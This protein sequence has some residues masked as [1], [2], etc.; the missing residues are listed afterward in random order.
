MLSLRIR[1]RL[2]L[3]DHSFNLSN[4]EFKYFLNLIHETTIENYTTQ[5]QDRLTRSIQKFYI[6]SF[7]YKTSVFKMIAFLNTPIAGFKN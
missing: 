7:T 4:I 3:S 5:K 2:I 6:S 1:T